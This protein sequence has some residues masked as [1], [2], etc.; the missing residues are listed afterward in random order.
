M[1]LNTLMLLNQSPLSEV[2]TLIHLYFQLFSLTLHMGRV[3]G[4]KISAYPL[5]RYS[6]PLHGAI[7]SE[8]PNFSYHNT[9]FKKSFSYNCL[10]I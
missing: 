4:K 9:T 10:C 5:F 3:V 7:C 1:S 8:I 6:D 2:Y